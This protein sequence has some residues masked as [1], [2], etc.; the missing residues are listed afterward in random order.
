MKKYFFIILCCFVAIYADAQTKSEKIMK[1][2]LEK[3][4]KSKE[5]GTVVLSLDTI[6]KSGVPYAILKDKKEFFRV[7]EYNLFSLNGT[8]LAYIP[9]ECVDKTTDCYYTFVFLDSGKKGEIKPSF[10]FDI[11]EVIV[12]NNLV[13]DTTLNAKAVDIFVLKHPQKLGLEK[14]NNQSASNNTDGIRYEMV[15]RDRDAMIQIFGERIEQGFKRIGTVK[16]TTWSADGKIGDLL[17]FYLPNGFK[18]AEAKQEDVTSDKYR[19]VTLKDNKFHYIDID[20]IAAT[21]EEI[22]KLLIDKY[23]L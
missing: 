18:I 9:F 11:E 4:A 23:Y 7:V 17:S 21:K 1:K 13:N 5:K 19:I 15:E 20:N 12:E 22:A 3:V 6:F 8:E 16:K 10:S 2:H 14:R